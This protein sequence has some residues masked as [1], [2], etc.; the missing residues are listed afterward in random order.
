MGYKR[1]G[2]APSMSRRAPQPPGTR[3]ARTHAAPASE[4]RFKSLDTYRVER[5]WKRYEGTAQRDLFRTLRFRFLARHPPPVEGPI[6]EVGPGP[7]RFSIELLAWRRPMMLLDLS[8]TMLQKARE[9]LGRVPSSGQPIGF[10]VGNGRNPPFRPH[11]FAQVLLL[12]NLLGFAST[13]AHELLQ[14][15]AELVRPD[16]QLLLETSP[17]SGESSRYLHRL[18]PTVIRRLLRSPLRALVP[19]V[20][21]E[22]FLPSRSA[23]KSGKDFRRLTAEEASSWLSKSGFEVGETLSVAPCFGVAREALEMVR[24]D[25]SG[26]SRLLELEE[27]IGSRPDRWDDAASL[28]VSARKSGRWESGAASP[29]GPPLSNVGRPPAPR[30]VSAVSHSAGGIK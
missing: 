28:L 19:R 3:S 5:E 27:E 11:T 24:P 20:I 22:G 1:L 10:L 9:T 17:G 30:R 12:G 8:R 13:S 29:G 18:P 16:G 7:G 25:E 15:C 6:L 26:W 21:R 2:C 14:R 4:A 23:E